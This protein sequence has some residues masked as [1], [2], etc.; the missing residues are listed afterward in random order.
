MGG[1]G[2]GLHHRGGAVLILAS[3]SPEAIVATT[4]GFKDLEDS[5]RPRGLLKRLADER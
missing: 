1:A 3:E 5:G 2:T 4:P